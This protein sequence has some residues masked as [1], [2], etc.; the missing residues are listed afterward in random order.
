M[1]Q[2]KYNSE[3]VTS[4][5]DD[6][7]TKHAVDAQK[8]NSYSK[9]NQLS[10][11]KG[12]GDNLAQPKDIGKFVSPTSTPRSGGYE[13]QQSH[14]EEPA[15]HHEEHH[16]EQHHEQHYE[17]PAQESYGGG[18]EYQ[19]QEEYHQEEYQQQEEYGGEEYQQEEYTEEYQ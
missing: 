17:E 16:E 8:K 7:H 11:Q 9:S 15:Q 18:E 5:A 1:T 10:Q 6:F 14:Y 19:Q 12:T 13:Q 2:D 4:V 3:K